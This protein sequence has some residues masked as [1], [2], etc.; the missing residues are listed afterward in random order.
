[1]P[2]TP[3]G[4]SSSKTFRHCR[5]CAA[6]CQVVES[7]LSHPCSRAGAEP[8]LQEC[9]YGTRRHESCGNTFI[10]KQAALPAGSVPISLEWGTAGCTAEAALAAIARDGAVIVRHAVPHRARGTV[11]IKGPGLIPFYKRSV[12]QLTSLS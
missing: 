5:C 8:P 12:E 4:M 1:M 7:H 11:E 10:C 3:G 9:V 2:P 6:P